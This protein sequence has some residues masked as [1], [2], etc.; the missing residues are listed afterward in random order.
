MSLKHLD[1]DV[2]YKVLITKLDEVA[3][4]FVILKLDKRVV[5]P[6]PGTPEEGH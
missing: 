4:S 2:F 1:K 6:C 5:P 3:A